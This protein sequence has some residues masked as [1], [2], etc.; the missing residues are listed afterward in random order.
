MRAL[1]EPLKDNAP[2][3]VL[4]TDADSPKALAIVRAVGRQHEV[5]TAAESRLALA[6]WSRYAKRH[7]TYSF[8]SIHDFPQWLLSTCISNGI[9]IVITP[10]EASS[11]L[12]A[13]HQSEF[14]ECGVRPT[15]L[16]LPALEAAMDKART[17]EVAAELG[18]PI[19][20][21]CTLDHT[22]DAVKAA[23]ELGYPLVLKPRFSRYWTGKEFIA[24][25]GVGY[26]TS[27]DQL[28]SL[29]RSLDPR[30]PPPL[31]QEFVP[32]TG[33]GVCL[34]IGA[35]GTLCAEFAHERL[36]DYRP[37]GSGS[38]LR[39]SAAVNP[40]LRELS[41][42]LLSKIGAHGVAM[43]EFRVDRRTNEPYLMEING[44]FWGSL[45]LAIDAG[46][47]FPE[48]L[49]DLALGRR[50]RKPAYQ[51]NVVLRWWI[52]DLVR[53][54]RVLKGKPEG[55]IGQFPSRL[56]ALREFLGPQPAGTRNEILRW[57]DWRPSFVEPISMMRKVFR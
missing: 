8:S 1:S 6:G 22:K 41:L 56:S 4:V 51:E 9:D 54:L 48:L 11:L 20:R 29:M 7:I 40:Q 35:D 25:D 32:G 42:R 15:N 17:V 50:L 2:A 43:V 14:I 44:R 49:V 31:L 30:L 19:P 12:V 57:S 23:H 33:C 3:R 37:T 53:T 10:E 55:Y 24:S 46:V 18:I 27:D 28:L 26:A 5:W 45:Q 21:T 39:R 13:H 36:R 16:P 34:L 52:G 38:V 47:N